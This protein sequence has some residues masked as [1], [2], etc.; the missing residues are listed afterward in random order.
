M[1]GDWTPPTLTRWWLEGNTATPDRLHIVSERALD[2]PP[3]PMDP[4]VSS[5]HG[6]LSPH[7][8][9]VTP[10]WDDGAHGWI[11]ATALRRER[12]D[13]T[14]ARKLANADRARAAQGVLL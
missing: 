9:G 14:K 11:E 12:P 10:A 6:W 3:C 1:M 7:G 2:A 4:P 5:E 13:E 8:V